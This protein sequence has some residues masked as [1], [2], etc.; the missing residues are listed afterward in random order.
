MPSD[1][2][3]G[4]PY[5]YTRV[6][7]MTTFHHASHTFTVDTYP[8]STVQ[9]IWAPAIDI[10]SVTR[11]HVLKRCRVC[12]VGIVDCFPEL[13]VPRYETTVSLVGSEPCSSWRPDDVRCLWRAAGHGIWDVGSGSASMLYGIAMREVV[14]RDARG[15]E[16]G[17]GGL[18]T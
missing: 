14:G 13:S 12:S 17:A 18:E 9:A 15:V 10:L 5:L 11:F 4:V 2:R 6:S 1:R 7:I 3:N 8:S 16:G